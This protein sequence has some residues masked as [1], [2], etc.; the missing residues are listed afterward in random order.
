M[1]QNELKHQCIG[2]EKELKHQCIGTETEVKHDDN[3]PFFGLQ[4]VLPDL[5]FERIRPR[6]ATMEIVV[7]ENSYVECLS[8]KR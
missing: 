1:R 4:A 7:A 2:T 8:I 5:E 6:L 3:D